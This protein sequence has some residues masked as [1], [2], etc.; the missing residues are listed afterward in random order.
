MQ[1][2]IKPWYKRGVI[3]VLRLGRRRRVMVGRL[4]RCMSGYSRRVQCSGGG[5]NT[6][7]NV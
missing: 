1:V 3:R 2:L 6:T 5:T 7:K 4:C